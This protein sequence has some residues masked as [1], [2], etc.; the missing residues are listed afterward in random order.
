MDKQHLT[1]LWQAIR[2]NPLICLVMLLCVV[3]YA[4]ASLWGFNPNNSLSYPESW[5][6]LFE[7]HQYW[8]LLTPVFIHFSL[9]HLLANLLVFW[10]LATPIYWYHRRVFMLLL[11]AA[12]LVGNGAEFVMI[13]EKFG[14]ISGV[15]FALFG[16]L[17]VFQQCQPKGPLYIDR[18]LSLGF[19]AF[20]LI[21]ATDW[22][23]HFA[24]YNHLGGFIVGAAFGFVMGI[25]RVGS[26]HA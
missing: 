11:L 3:Q 19:L 25:R 18:S 13:D 24:F 20:L 10:L 6:S 16:F 4:Y 23:G 8:R 12:A 7:T 26:A 17:L 21:S 14:G 9:M 15:N 5:T 22:L 2:L 1:Q